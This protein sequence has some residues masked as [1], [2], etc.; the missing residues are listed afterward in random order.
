M[1]LKCILK[2]AG[3]FIGILIIFVLYMGVLMFVSLWSSKMI[4]QYVT[5]SVN[6]LYIMWLG[7]VFM[8]ILSGLSFATFHCYM[9][10]LEKK[11]KAKRESEEKVA[12]DRVL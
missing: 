6:V 10:E 5:G 7:L 1:N 12:G 2:E 8:I 3:I 9:T 4:I 11:K